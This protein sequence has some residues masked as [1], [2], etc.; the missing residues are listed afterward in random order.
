MRNEKN[1][2][3][4]HLKM[5]NYLNIIHLPHRED[6]FE[7]LTGELVSQD[8]FACIWPGILNPEDPKKGISKAHKQVVAWAKQQQFPTV[9]IAEDDIRF[10][11]PGAFDHFIKNRP[12]D[13]DLYLGG[14]YYGKIKPD[15][16]VEDFAGT[17]LYIIH[18]RFYDTFLS[19]DENVHIDR[20][21]VG[22]G[23]FVVCNPFAAI[24]HNGYSDNKGCYMNYDS[25]LDDKQLFGH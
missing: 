17:M 25:Y 24:Q 4:F 15:N 14:I 5:N 8:L 1:S 19:I 22:K 13:F 23:R 12:A 10:T 20:G 2:L 11:A 21:L 18:E 6:R 9:I 16:T 3:P 7:L